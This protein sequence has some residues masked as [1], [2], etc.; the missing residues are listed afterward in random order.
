MN[1][2][3]ETNKQVNEKKYTGKMYAYI[4]VALTAAGALFL[5]LSFT[6]MGIYSLITSLILTLAALTF[7]NVQ[8][9]KNDFKQ[10][11]IIKIITYAVFAAAI[12][13]FVGGVFYSME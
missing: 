8:K 1:N 2:N 6:V 3:N 10:L 13:I 4:A 9:R 11:K 7:E 12:I 5:G